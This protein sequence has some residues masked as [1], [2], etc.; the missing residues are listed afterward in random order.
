[1]HHGMS[2]KNVRNPERAQNIEMCY[3]MFALVTELE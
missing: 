1:M 2:K 3:L